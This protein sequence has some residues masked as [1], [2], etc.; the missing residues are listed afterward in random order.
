MLCCVVYSE[1]LCF[2]FRAKL[3]PEN[4]GTKTLRNVRNLLTQ[5]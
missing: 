4:E 3:D 1:E 5:R 2:T